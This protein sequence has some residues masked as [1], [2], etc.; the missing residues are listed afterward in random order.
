MTRLVPLLLLALAACPRDTSRA[1]RQEII[2]ASCGGF[3]SSS[4][5]CRDVISN[6]KYCYAGRCSSTLPAS[7]VDAGVDAP[8]STR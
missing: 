1:V 2:G 7:P 5:E 6:C 3:C 4:A 8:G